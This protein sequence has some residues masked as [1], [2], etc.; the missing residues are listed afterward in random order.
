VDAHG[1][2]VRINGVNVAGFEQKQGVMEGLEFRKLDDIAKMYRDQG[3]NAVRLLWSDEMATKNPVVD[4]K[5][6]KANHDLIGKTSLQIMDAAINAFGR[7]GLMILLDHHVEDSGWCCSNGAEGSWYNSRYPEK[8]VI[9][10]EATMVARY[11]QGGE[12]PNQAVVAMEGANELR[13][14]PAGQVVWDGSGSPTD[15]QQGATRLDAAVQ[16]ANPKILFVVDGVSWST[17]LSGVAEHPIPFKNI[18]YA[19]HTYD[20]NLVGL[21]LK[22][23]VSPTWL[24]QNW[25]KHV[26]Y[27]LQGHIA[28]VWLTE[29]GTN[30]SQQSSMD[31]TQ[32]EGIFFNTLR[33]LI[34]QNKL[35]WFY[36]SGDPTRAG[37]TPDNWSV[38]AVNWHGPQIDN[39][40]KPRLLAELQ[41]IMTALRG[42][43]SQATS[44]SRYS[45]S[46]PPH[47][48][49]YVVSPKGHPS[50]GVS[51]P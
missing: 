30:G 33:R 32:P 10:D 31:P 11:A 44:I 23:R 42:W 40:G 16:A 1:N 7:E 8:Q 14:G 28:P 19:F 27:I 20:F 51:N 21:P 18:V 37:T 45:P 22:D 36:W 47:A 41:A 5:Y 48:R 43:S 25:K 35:S 12:D 46:P 49:Q 38:E 17:D 15:W 2:I 6:L 9:H 34:S 26:M 4:A 24:M 3:F 39:T 29:F 13:T 50:S